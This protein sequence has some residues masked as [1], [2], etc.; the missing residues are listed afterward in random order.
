MRFS[1]LAQAL[2]L[3]TTLVLAAGCSDG[4]NPVS[5]TGP[6][7][8]LPIDPIE[9]CETAVDCEE[10]GGGGDD[11]GVSPYSCGPYSSANAYISPYCTGGPFGGFQSTSGTGYQTSITVWL[12]YAASAVTATALD[13]DLYGNYMAAYNS[14]GSEVGRV[15]FDYDGTSGTFTAST[16]TVTGSG[17]VRVVLVNNSIDYVA[18]DKV[19]TL[20]PYVTGGP[21]GGFQ[22][23]SGTGYQTPITVRFTHPQS[24]VTVTA[25]DPDY[26]G[27]YIAA[28][29][30]SGSE[31]ARSYFAYDGTPGVFTSSTQSVYAPGSIYNVALVNHRSDYIAYDGLSFY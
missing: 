4:G 18:W 16:K 20:D 19:H 27:N 10:D 17:I 7:M 12:T 3:G 29:N 11:H 25:L 15:Y 31:L 8:V 26:A 1:P 21:F 22:S 30:G 6:R 24:S 2:V 5:P 28:L 23:A 9:P 13:P 14:S